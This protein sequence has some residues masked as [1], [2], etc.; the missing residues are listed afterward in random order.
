MTVT[1]ILEANLLIVFEAT[2][3]IAA[4]LYRCLMIG[5]VGDCY[6][7]VGMGVSCWQMWSLV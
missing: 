3:K 2:W 6:L 7:Y 1:Y 5:D 4:C